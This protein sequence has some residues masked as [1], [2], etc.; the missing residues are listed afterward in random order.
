MNLTKEQK[1]HRQ[2]A[3]KRGDWVRAA[4]SRVGPNFDTDYRG[5]ESI[6]QDAKIAAWHAFRAHPE[7]RD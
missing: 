3:R 5:V 6:Y 4:I 7:L 1:Y 2:Q